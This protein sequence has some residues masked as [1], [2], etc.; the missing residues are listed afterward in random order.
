MCNAIPRYECIPNQ[1]ISSPPSGCRPP[2][3][4]K[5][6]AVQSPVKLLFLGWNPPKSYGGF[7][8]DDQD[9]L[10]RE[11]HAI[12]N[13]KELGLI[14]ASSPN[15]S[16]LDE[17]L[18]NGFYFIHTVKCWTEAKFPGFGRG[19]KTGE[20][21]EVGIPL[22]KSCVHNHLEEELNTLAPQKVCA[23]GEVPFLGLCELFQKLT[24]TK[25]T[26]TQGQ[27]F[28]REQYGIPWPLLYTC[29][30]Q[31][32]TMKVRGTECR[33]PASDIALGHLREFLQS[34]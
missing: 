20:R 11:L 24:T 32:Q 4:Y 17:F 5:Y 22:I 7:W 34:H 18:K 9:N 33:K 25:A 28:Q 16:F 12:L 1:Q 21:K 26:P 31:G 13:S 2:K 19:A 23:L 15:Q 8:S 3:L 27:V 10:R 6:P 14:N 30:P 29:F